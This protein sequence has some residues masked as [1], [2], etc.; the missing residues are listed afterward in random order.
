MAE[1]TKRTWPWK[2]KLQDKAAPESLESS[3]RGSP[4]NSKFFDEQQDVSKILSEHARFSDE[5]MTHWQHSESKLKQLSDNLHAAQTELTAKDILV[6][7]HAKVAE[8]AVTGWEKAEAE[9]AA[10]KQ[11]LD[12]ITHQKSATEDRVSHLDGALKECMRQLRFVREEQEQ[13]IH[14]TI[15]IKT[16]EYD[17]FR[18]EMEAKLA[19]VDHDLE[20]ARAELLESRGEVRATAIVLDESKTHFEELNNCKAR[21]EAEVKLLQLKLESMEK[22]IST[23]NFELQSLRKELEIRNEEREY[24]RRA[25]E[26]AGKN[27]VENGKKIAQLEAE[28]HRLRVLM[29]KKL[30]GPAAVAQMKI[31]VDSLDASDVGSDSKGRALGVG[32]GVRLFSKESTRQSE[33]RKE[34]SCDRFPVESGSNRQAGVL[35][36]RL[37]GMDDELKMLKETLSR[38][39]QE[40]QVSRLMCAKTASKLSNVEEQL[41]ITLKRCK[42]RSIATH[43]LLQKERLEVGDEAV[44]SWDAASALL[45]ELDQ[46]KTANYR[47]CNVG[48]VELMD[49]FVEMER[50]AMATGKAQPDEEDFY[51]EVSDKCFTD[52]ATP[53]EDKLIAKERELAEANRLRNEIS[54]QL[55]QAEEKVSALQSRNSANETIL[56]TLQAKLDMFCDK[57]GEDDGV[58]DRNI[59]KE[60]EDLVE[61]QSISLKAGASHEAILYDREEGSQN[62]GEAR[63]GLQRYS[64]SRSGS[65]MKCEDIEDRD[66]VLSDLE[67]KSVS[68]ASDVVLTAVLRVVQ[69]VAALVQAIGS[70]DE[71]SPTFEFNY[72]N[73]QE[74]E[75]QVYNL[76]QGKHPDLYGCMRSFLGVSGKFLQGKTDVVDFLTELAAVLKHLTHSPSRKADHLVERSE[77]NRDC[78]SSQETKNFL[79]RFGLQNACVE[80]K[81]EAL[82]EH[83]RGRNNGQV[84]GEGGFVAVNQIFES[85]NIV[86]REGENFH[87]GLVGSNGNLVGERRK[88]S[89]S[90]YELDVDTS[91]LYKKVAALEGELQEERQRHQELELK[92]L[93]LQQ[94]THSRGI[95][96]SSSAGSITKDCS[97]LEWGGS[98]HQYQS[99]DLG[100]GDVRAVKDVQIQLAAEKLAECQ[101]SILDLGKQLKDLGS[102]SICDSFNASFHSETACS[103]DKASVC[104]DHNK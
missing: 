59:T 71:S 36:E 15:V 92:Y 50:M 12:K 7:Q 86:S 43:G 9:A 53:L 28:C 35:A 99:S 66:S 67:Y 34:S 68:L 100:G 30:P 37:V 47:R 73:G 22:E 101:Q 42:R 88:W 90:K 57:L 56:V 102:S 78:P 1:P 96:S 21:S 51:E 19:E 49:D 94:Q 16:R 11:Q 83:S 5:A 17:K 3:P 76:R 87:S 85:E 39:E 72:Q 60:L 89:I 25:A 70:G 93:D 103:T 52:I 55:L 33:L 80:S 48:Q 45:A 26:N 18:Q 62:G 41:E 79:W 10:L 91:S 63:D 61:A 77:S 27:Q 4:H 69:V 23:S 74:S 38:R 40:L 95:G 29:R 65:E 98:H 81:L 75:I 14:E 46:F 20:V 64:S 84:G 58:K 13:R 24:E 6:K 31:E 32:R 54:Q 8:E 104:V 97:E 2:K 82:E 44:D